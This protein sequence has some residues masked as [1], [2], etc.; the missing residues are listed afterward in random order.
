MVRLHFRQSKFDFFVAVAWEQEDMQRFSLGD[1][2]ILFQRRGSLWE[3]LH[4][5]IWEQ[6]CP[7]S[8][9]IMYQREVQR[10]AQWKKTGAWHKY[11]EI[12]IV[13]GSLIY[14]LDFFFFFSFFKWLSLISFLS[15]FHHLP[16]R[17]CIHQLNITRKNVSYHAW[18]VCVRRADALEWFIWLHHEH[19]GWRK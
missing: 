3:A 19:L 16:P 4:I 18:G 15:I 7:F 17:R 5:L 9:L 8:V 13:A 2:V 10:G 11:L 12:T 6:N 1:Y 14:I